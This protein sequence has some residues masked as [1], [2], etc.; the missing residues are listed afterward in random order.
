MQDTVRVSQHPHPVATGV[1]L[2]RDPL[3]TLTAD[4]RSH[5]LVLTTKVE[6]YSNGSFD[7]VTVDIRIPQERLQDVIDF[8]TLA[9]GPKA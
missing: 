9:L 2:S 1:V 6:F 3:T 8:A 4:L 5:E 7:S